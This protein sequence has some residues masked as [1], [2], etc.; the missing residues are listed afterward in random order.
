MDEEAYS[1]PE[2]R[3]RQP[4]SD[5]QIEHIAQRAA[6]LAVQKMTTDIYASVGKSVMQKVFWIV[7]V[8]ATAMVLGNASIKEL[9]K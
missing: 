9:L 2:R 1:G 3:T 8:V 6:E 4:L 7:G 5:E